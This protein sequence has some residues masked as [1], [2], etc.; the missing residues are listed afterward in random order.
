MA[1]C[2]DVVWPVGSRSLGNAPVEALGPGP[3]ITGIAWG[4]PIVPDVE[5]LSMPVAA[6]APADGGRAGGATGATVRGSSGIGFSD[7]AG[8]VADGVGA[9]TGAGVGWG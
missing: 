9:R 3:G 6:G 2:H 8:L 7:G 5:G 4:P 1:G